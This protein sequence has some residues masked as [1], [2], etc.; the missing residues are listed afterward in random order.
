MNTDKKSTQIMSPRRQRN[1]E[2]M[3]QTILETARAIMREDGVA[4]LSMH[5]LARRLEI[6]PPS[7]YNYFSG[8]MDIYDALFRL[9]FTLWDKHVKEYTQEAKTWQDEIGLA[10]EAYM[11]F[12]LQNPALY[13]LCFERPVP[14]FV[15]SEESLKVS[16]NSLEEL[17][18]HVANL[19][20]VIQT[21]LPPKQLAD[22]VIAISHGLTAL[23][24]ANEPHLPLGHGRFGALIPAALSILDKAWSKP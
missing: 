18:G 15:P 20:N 17:Y 9:G 6:R 4:A 5:E 10:M 22:L 1:R 21:D 2:R 14:G 24:M 19:Q 13:Q 8:L 12:A 23:H 11:T 7:L 16:F 3:I